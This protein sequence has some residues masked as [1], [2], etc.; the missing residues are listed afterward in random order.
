M[1]N[2]SFLAFLLFSII[3]VSGCVGSTSTKTDKETPSN[4]LVHDSPTYGIKIAYPP[5]M[6]KEEFGTY[7]VFKPKGGGWDMSVTLNVEYLT[8]P[9]TF[10]EYTNSLK[11]AAIGIGINDTVD[12][13]ATG[14]TTLANIPAYQVV[15]SKFYGTFGGIEGNTKI[16]KT[17]K[18][19]TVKDNKVYMITYTADADRYSD[20]LK[21]VQKMIDS[22]EI[23]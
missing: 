17:M 3:I 1:K 23:L 9:M 22:F 4:F 8:K 13:Q 19:W 14:R 10:D 20:F 21:T 5:D 2:F 15:Y 6:T 12:K 7:V 18:I 11:T 16:F